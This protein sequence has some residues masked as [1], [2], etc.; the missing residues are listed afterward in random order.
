MLYRSRHERAPAAGPVEL[1]SISNHF[2]RNFFEPVLPLGRL[3]SE[4]WLLLV[5]SPVRP[6]FVL[7][8]LP[9]DD[10]HSEQHFL[11]RLSLNSSGVFSRSQL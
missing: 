2:N 8:R 1:A 4:T 5:S 6:V 11:F 7:K 3:S 10:C 9:A